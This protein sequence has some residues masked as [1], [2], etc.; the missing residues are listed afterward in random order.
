MKAQRTLNPNVFVKDEDA[1]A[2]RAH[3]SRR[4]KEAADPKNRLPLSELKKH[5]AKRI[6]KTINA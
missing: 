3:I 1:P 6:S 2:F 4:V 5:L